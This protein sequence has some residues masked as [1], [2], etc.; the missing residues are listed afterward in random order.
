MLIRRESLPVYTK[1]T[2]RRSI[3]LV[4]NIL[5]ALISGITTERERDKEK[6]KDKER[7]NY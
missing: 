4:N 1:V 6:E 3:F 7:D 2:Q 5:R